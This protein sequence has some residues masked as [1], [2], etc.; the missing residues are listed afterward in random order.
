M[1]HQLFGLEKNSRSRDR[2]KFP[3]KY[4]STHQ[5][6]YEAEAAV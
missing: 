1:L 6:G 3:E 4:D 5:K 2:L